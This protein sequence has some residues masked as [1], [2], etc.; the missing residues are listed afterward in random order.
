[1][2]KH[3]GADLGQRAQTL[4]AAVENG[5][6]KRAESGVSGGV[7]ATSC[8]QLQ[9]L[10]WQLLLPP[11]AVTRLQTLAFTSF[12]KLPSSAHFSLDSYF[13]KPTGTSKP[14]FS[15]FLIAEDNKAS[16]EAGLSSTVLFPH[17]SLA[18]CPPRTPAQTTLVQQR[19]DCQERFQIY[20]NRLETKQNKLLNYFDSLDTS[21]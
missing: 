18:P 7:H 10:P 16:P 19:G 17:S 21:S 15:R 4:A 3:A 1:M 14:N 8:R 13:L 9:T 6:R 5:G 11:P 12:P 20:V 2:S